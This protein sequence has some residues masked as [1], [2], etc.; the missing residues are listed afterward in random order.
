[1]YENT[2]AVYGLIRCSLVQFVVYDSDSV[3][4]HI[5]MYMTEFCC[6]K[7]CEGGGGSGNVYRVFFLLSF[8][9]F[10]TGRT[11]SMSNLLKN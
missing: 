11:I 10:S 2:Q 9:V 4:Y 3:I 6:K 7:I 1:M 5:I 8:F